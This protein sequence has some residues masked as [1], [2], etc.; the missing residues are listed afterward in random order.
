MAENDP[1][2]K[3]LKSMVHKT[4][5]NIIIVYN[6]QNHILLNFKK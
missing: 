5:K 4:I 1:G 6:Y 2:H 3:D